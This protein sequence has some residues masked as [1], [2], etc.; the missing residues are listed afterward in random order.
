M[1]TLTLFSL[2]FTLSSVTAGT[3][4]TRQ[5]FENSVREDSTSKESKW[6]LKL[7]NGC[8]AFFLKSNNDKAYVATAQ[9]CT[10]YDIYS[11]CRMGGIVET[12][13]GTKGYCTKVIAAKP[14]YDIVVIETNFKKVPGTT[15]GYELA[16]FDPPL[17]SRLRM[18]G[19]PADKYKQGKLTTTS[20]CWVLKEDKASIYPYLFDRSG[21]HNC[22]T[23]G[24]NSGGPM[25]LEGT[26]A[27]IGLPFT[28]IPNNYTLN[29]PWSLKTAA[30][31][32]KMS[33]FV[34]TH[35]QALEN[36]KI[37]IADEIPEEVNYEK[38]DQE[39]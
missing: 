16:S 33:D 4:S 32:A 22:T 5:F 6:T 25:V 9:H 19:H 35:R 29:D 21:L 17:H 24:G 10:G 28:Y 8:T 37:A 3:F 14:K 1:K 31:L 7:Q 2:I 26:N 18:I 34:K 15:N 11:W 13:G 36:A 30:H 39:E 27:V 20:N 38:K 12:H 23:Y